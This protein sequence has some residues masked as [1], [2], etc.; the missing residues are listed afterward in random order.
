[1]PL[2]LGAAAVAAGEGR[3]DG[4]CGAEAELGQLTSGATDKIALSC[5]LLFDYFS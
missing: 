1:M 3:G 2:H 4:G 5:I